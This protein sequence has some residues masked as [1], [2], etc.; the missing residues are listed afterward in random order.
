MHAERTTTPPYPPKHAK[1]NKVRAGGSL[2]DRRTKWARGQTS[3]LRSE[4]ATG[5]FFLRSPVSG[6][7]TREGPGRSLNCSVIVRDNRGA[8]E[9]LAEKL[10]KLSA[11][12]LGST[13][14]RR[15]TLAARG[16]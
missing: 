7:R 10:P 15:A 5:H 1:Q 3:I 12:H 13:R 9:I 4:N 6:R 8:P 16:I 14:S 11:G 2:K